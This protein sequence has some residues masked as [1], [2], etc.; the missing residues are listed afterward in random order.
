MVTSFP[1]DGAYLLSKLFDPRWRF[2]S[3]G[4]FL[5]SQI[6]AA[7]MGF[8]F[9]FFPPVIHVFPVRPVDPFL[10]R[11]QERPVICLQENVLGHLAR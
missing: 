8:F 10:L 2:P 9:S 7:L 6:P 3:T 1:S 4:E 11:D 5:N